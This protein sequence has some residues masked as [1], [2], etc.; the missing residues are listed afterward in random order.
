MNY[1]KCLCS[2]LRLRGLALFLAVIHLPA[3]AVASP[4]IEPFFAADAFDDKDE[5]EKAGD[6]EQVRWHADLASA[7]SDARVNNRRVFV[8]VGADWCTFCKQLEDEIAGDTEKRIA[9][10]FTMAK[11]DAEEQIKDATSLEANALPALRVV[12]T[13][14]R[15]VER[16][17]G[18][19]N[20][21]AL[22]DWLQTVPEAS[23]T[24]AILGKDFA[25]LDAA[26]IRKLVALLGERDVTLRSIVLE[27]LSPKPGEAS[28]AVIDAFK[29]GSLGFRLAAM[30]LLKQWNAPVA[31]ID[32]WTPKSINQATLE[33]LQQWQRDVAK[34][35]PEPNSSDDETVRRALIRQ[36]IE[37][38]LTQ[39]EALV[40]TEIAAL[41][42]DTD[43]VHAEGT[44]WMKRLTQSG[45]PHP[46]RLRR[47]VYGLSASP[48]TRLSL[49]G[50]LQ[51]LAIADIKARRLAADVVTEA[52]G[53]A[54]LPLL[55]ALLAD[56]DALIRE[57]AL[58]NLA[59]VAPEA[60]TARL[61][62]LLGDPD[63]NVRAGV[64][65]QLAILKSTNAIA[66]VQ[67][68]LNT[69]QD[70]DLLIYAIRFL[71]ATEDEQAVSA[72]LDQVDRPQWRV[73]AAAIEAIGEGVRSIGASVDSRVRKAARDAILTAVEDE[74]SFVAAKAA[75]QIGTIVSPA[76]VAAV[77]DVAKKRP[78]LIPQLSTALNAD[79]KTS[80]QLVK[81]MRRRVDTGS[82]SDRDFAISMALNIRRNRKLDTSP[83]SMFPPAMLV[84]VVEESESVETSRQAMRLL[85][86]D[87]QQSLQ[88]DLVQ[89]LPFKSPDEVFALGTDTVSRVARLVDGKPFESVTGLVDLFAGLG[90]EKLEEKEPTP[91]A[92]DQSALR[93]VDEFFDIEPEVAGPSKP[94]LPKPKTQRQFM[95]ALWS[96]QPARLKHRSMYEPIAERLSRLRE[97]HRDPVLR[98]LVAAVQ[99]TGA[100]NPG[101]VDDRSWDDILGWINANSEMESTDRF[102]RTYQ[103][104]LLWVVPS[105]GEKTGGEKL[106]DND[107]RQQ[108]LDA[109]WDHEDL[110]RQR[111][112]LL[113]SAMPP[114]KAT[115]EFLLTQ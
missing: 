80:A 63:K 74:D 95:T 60:D 96:G 51:A 108:L 70:T 85:L 32:P 94:L 47:L 12:S 34:E 109:L 107:Q 37:S 28:G 98:G 104:R 30:R 6:D 15:L 72:L 43:L 35:S 3:P 113:D 69:E 26:E 103:S 110:R 76:S 83:D 111:E 38:L 5:E 2:G 21:D 45:D 50:P 91:V 14:G 27:R 41:A 20:S 40:E 114:G 82:D 48:E 81:E 105:P 93:R 84:A 10:R 39:R 75:S 87:L 66:A 58:Q 71:R 65:K 79:A 53:K 1:R 78:E 13:S 31:E 36:R 49:R 100:P 9:E 23:E 59:R 89:S 44:A 67:Q 7:I 57:L 101:G 112:L 64:L 17:D 77:I 73:R 46:N 8:I 115:F 92:V 4:P 61:T 24:D 106:V 22:L 97:R 29:S 99:V 54:D 25:E 18:Y 56:E 88:R 33:Q 42:S 102:D 62:E 19:L 16:R 68:Y 11:I 90:L 86:Q 52:A 55:T